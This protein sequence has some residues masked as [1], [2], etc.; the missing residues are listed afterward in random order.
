MSWKE[1][2]ED[3]RYRPNEYQR[4]WSLSEHSGGAGREAHYAPTDVTVSLGRRPGAREY[5]DPHWYKRR[6]SPLSVAPLELEV[7][8][9]LPD[10]CAAHGRPAVS[11]LL[12]RSLFYETTV[13]PRHPQT[14]RSMGRHPTP[15]ST[16]VAGE[17]PICDRCT[18]RRQWYHGTA[19]VLVLV[20]ALNVIAMIVV[21][22]VLE[23]EPLIVPLAVATFPGS[24]PI[25]L[26]VALLLY[27][28]GNTRVQVRP[29]DDER[30]LRV[31]AHPNFAAALHRIPSPPP[32]EELPPPRLRLENGRVVPD[33]SAPNDRTTRPQRPTRWGA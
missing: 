25:G 19:G 28:K 23:Y 15:V 1:R 31:D 32:A 9:P 33:C 24:L 21:A 2:I 27:E 11:R 18:R 26:I 17:W 22:R 5:K 10:V 13:H 12:V 7:I 16:I 4:M 29:I 14:G 20:M 3:V 8:Q 30:F 6:R